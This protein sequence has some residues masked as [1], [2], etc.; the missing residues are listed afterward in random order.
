MVKPSL[1]E[2]KERCLKQNLSPLIKER[3]R[4]SIPVYYG[5]YVT[6]P[7]SIRIVRLLYGTRVTPNHVTILS[8]SVAALSAFLF[9]HGGKAACLAGAGLF[10]LF[11]ILDCVDGQLARAK[12]LASAGGKYLDI[13]SNFLVPPLVLFGIGAGVA[14]ASPSRFHLYSLG[15][16]PFAVMAIQIMDML[17]DRIYG[18]ESTHAGFDG[19]IDERSGGG[20][21][22]ILM[23]KAYSV[24]YRSF[25]MPVIMNIVT[26]CAIANLFSGRNVFEFV[27]AYFSSVGTVIWITKLNY[28]V[29]FGAG[30]KSLSGREGEFL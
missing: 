3:F 18:Q 12:G 4:K 11:Y 24:L 22:A 9:S 7:I 2:L 17:R 8:I 29:F 19:K 30:R 14:A 16:M 6:H 27:T 15:A 1:Q 21:A 5:V 23:R 28:L 20:S 10:E 26:V 25:T 13:F